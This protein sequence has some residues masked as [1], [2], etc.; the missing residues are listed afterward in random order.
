MT[1]TDNTIIHPKTQNKENKTKNK[2]EIK[3]LRSKDVSL[4]DKQR[5]QCGIQSVS[6]FLNT[7]QKNRDHLDRIGEN[8]LC[9]M[10]KVS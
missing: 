7:R 9:H 8:Y 3:V 6:K 10:K 4:K 1:L 5:E 2:V